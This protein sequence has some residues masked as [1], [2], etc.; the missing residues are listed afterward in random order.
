MDEQAGRTTI[1][2]H[3][4][5]QGSWRME[6]LAPNERLAP[7]VRRFNAY[8]ERDTG[9]TR[10][11]E[12]P[13]PLATLVFNLGRELRVEH[14]LNTRAIYPAGGAFYSGLSSAYAVTETDRAQEGAQVMLTPLGARRLLGFPLAEVG[15]RLI[16]PCDLIGAPARAIAEGLQE[17]NSSSGRLAILEQA[18]T[19][20]LAASPDRIPADL[21]W[22]LRRLEAT[23]GRVGV[24]TLADEIGCSRKHL[25]VRFRREFGLPPKLFARVARFDRAVG[26]MRRG[27][28]ESHAR[29]AGEC[30][31]A[32]QAHLTREFR[33]F[34]GDP[35]A[36]F[37]RRRLADQGGFV[38]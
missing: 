25:T 4:S 3:A 27:R 29:L 38:D 13:A 35:P 31:Y 10:R 33:Q 32:D 1:V 18:M 28:A 21:T 20:R 7:F 22:A 15:D 24:N 36:A 2:E 14:P 6:V 34:A 8:S 23:F 9:F 12:L 17:T 37:L 5:P 26:L 11:R 16:D 19:E 30:G